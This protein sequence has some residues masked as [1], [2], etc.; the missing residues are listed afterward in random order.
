MSQKGQIPLTQKQPQNTTHPPYSVECSYWTYPVRIL[1]VNQWGSMFG[2]FCIV[3]LLLLKSI[4][5]IDAW[6]KHNVYE[7][8]VLCNRLVSH[9]VSKIIYCLS[10]EVCMLALWTKLLIWSYRQYPNI[11][12][13][14]CSVSSYTWQ[15]KYQR[16]YFVFLF[17]LINTMA[18]KSSRK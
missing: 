12:E 5:I 18:W 4:K 14:T 9:A 13:I 8:N 2:C 10:Y 3:T 1:A 15:A 7:R 17:C 16:P 11:E 6:C